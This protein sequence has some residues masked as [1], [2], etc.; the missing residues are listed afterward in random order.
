MSVR[1]KQQERSGMLFGGL[2]VACFSVTLPATRI[3][4]SHI[5]PVLFGL[6]RSML[7]LPLAILTL[8]WLRIPLPT[9]AQ[10]K[11]LLWVALGAVIVFPWLTAVAMESVSASQGGIVVAVLP[12]F[13][14]V[15][16]AFLARQ[17]PSIGFWS[18]MLL[19]CL[20]VVWFVWDDSKGGMGQGD[21]ILLFASVLCAIS[22]AVGGQLAKQMGGVAV[23]CWALV[24]A[25][26]VSLL[27]ILC[28]MPEQNYSLPSRAWLSF[29]YVA[30]V[31]QWLAFILWYQ[32]M[33]L[34]GVVRVSQVQLLQPFLTLCVS[35]WLLSEVID[36]EM[37]WFA[38]AV[39]LTVTVGR[40]MSISEA[41]KPS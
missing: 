5:D 39:V 11:H 27:V 18:M 28:L 36:S 34:G 2:A 35:A 38:L 30:I 14:A 37:L 31:S 6:G 40:S 26:P 16:G 20:L 29:M 17:R 21:L 13:T 41:K 19:G 8:W 33:S 1:S 10:V 15:V 4:V 32:G 3:G 12:L 9:W 23:I 22:Y 7:V 25:A 24:L